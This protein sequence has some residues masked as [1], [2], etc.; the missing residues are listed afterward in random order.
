M[1]NLKI[2]NGKISFLTKSTT[3]ANIAKLVGYKRKVT[4]L[5]VT[6]GYISVY[7]AL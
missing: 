6:H 2:R 7:I 1:K 4:L 5:K 3:I